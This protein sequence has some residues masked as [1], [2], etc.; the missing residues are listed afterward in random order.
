MNQ[1]ASEQNN[2]FSFYLCNIN[3]MWFSW[4]VSFFFFFS[5]E[6]FFFLGIFSLLH[7]HKNDLQCNF[8]LHINI[9]IGVQRWKQKLVYIIIMNART[10]LIPTYCT[11]LC[12][13]EFNIMHFSCVFLID[14]IFSIIL[15]YYLFLL[16][17]D[18]MCTFLWY[19]NLRTHFPLTLD[20]MHHQNYLIKYRVT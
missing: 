17:F 4:L 8:L 9:G 3:I 15:Y 18:R 2:C 10:H 6:I 16:N 11:L 19:C 5:F 7:F 12:V 14:F 20:S 1:I 13:V